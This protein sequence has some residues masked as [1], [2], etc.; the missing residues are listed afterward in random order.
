MEAAAHDTNST[1]A[2][3]EGQRRK[4]TWKNGA[5]NWGENEELAY[6][7]DLSHLLH[8]LGYP[9]T[10]ERCIVWRFATGCCSNPTTLVPVPRWI[11]HVRGTPACCWPGSAFSAHLIHQMH[12]RIFS[13]IEMENKNWEKKVLVT[14]R[15]CWVSNSMEKGLKQ[16]CS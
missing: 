7:S 13:A 4:K 15:C 2:E 9:T 10:V 11:R 3:N 14:L 16:R 12:V 5:Q 6:L 8:S 1:I